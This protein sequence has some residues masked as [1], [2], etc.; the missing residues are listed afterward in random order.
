MTQ[1]AHTKRNFE[2]LDT[3]ASEPELI[4]LLAPRRYERPGVTGGFWQGVRFAFLVIAPIYLVV[5]YIL[6]R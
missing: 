1:T 4:A 5:I 6:L 2:G 3:W